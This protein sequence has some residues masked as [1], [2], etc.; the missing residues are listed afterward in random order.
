MTRHDINCFL[1]VTYQWNGCDV[2]DVKTKTK[3]SGS[4]CTE[5]DA[6]NYL[7][8]MSLIGTGKK[9]GVSAYEALTVAFSGNA[10]IGLL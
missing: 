7:D 8:I 1:K 2:R 6:Q 9:Y 10:E 4:F 3:V 5:T